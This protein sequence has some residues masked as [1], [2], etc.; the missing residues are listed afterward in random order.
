MGSIIFRL[1]YFWDNDSLND[2]FKNSISTYS[3]AD[4]VIF[5]FDFFSRKKKLKYEK[6]VGY[7]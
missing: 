1:T 4:K 3:F 2:E 5:F 7:L 6:Y